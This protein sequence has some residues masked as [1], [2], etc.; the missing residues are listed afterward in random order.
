MRERLPSL[1]VGAHQAVY[2]CVNLIEDERVLVITDDAAGRIPF[3]ILDQVAKM[4]PYYNIAFME[5][6]GKRDP[7]GKNP[8]AFPEELYQGLSEFDVSFYIAGSMP[9]EFASF[10]KPMFEAIKENKKLRH[11]HMIGINEQIMLDGMA[12]DYKRVQKITARVY[13]RAVQAKTM[14]IVTPAGTNLHIDFTPEYKWKVCDGLITEG[15]WSNLPGGEVF[16]TPKDVNGIM[17]V[18]GVLGDYFSKKYGSL[19]KTPVQ[20][21]MRKNQIYDIFC[22]NSKLEKEFMEYTSRD[23][24]SSTI[25]EVAIGTN[26]G[27][28]ELIGNLL[29][30]EKFPGNHNAWGDPLGEAT[31]APWE[32]SV[33]C[34]GVQRECTITL[35][36]KLLMDKG[37]FVSEILK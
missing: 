27:L 23:R 2:N 28:K 31:G 22:E 25:G 29:Q 4:T 9:G 26:I 24:Y 21:T 14:H 8:L 11:A 16:T 12:V 7:T 20:V 6:Y 35:D 15:N 17:V 1:S 30:D 10:R 13:E 18:D 19:D 5:S 36:D 33:H 34:D 37:V 32:S 3:A